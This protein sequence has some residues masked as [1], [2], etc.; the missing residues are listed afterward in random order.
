MRLAALLLITFFAAVSPALAS[1]DTDGDGVPD[2]TDNCIAVY[3]SAQDDLDHDGIGDACDGDVDGDGCLNTADPF[4]NDPREHR[5][6]DGD[7]VGDNA[8]TPTDGA[9]A[10]EPGDNCPGA[11]NPTQADL[12]HDG[13]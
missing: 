6:T 5:D 1:V 12:D 3:N 13:I 9:G 8:D 10:A 4:P 7:G 11:P 2:G